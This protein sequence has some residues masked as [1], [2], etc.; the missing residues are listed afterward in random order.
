MIGE[1]T[2]A[3]MFLLPTGAGQIVRTAGERKHRLRVVQEN[4]R[5]VEVMF[6][7]G[8]FVKLGVRRSRPIHEF[9]AATSCATARG[10]AL[11]TRRGD[12][13]FPID[14]AVDGI[15]GHRNIPNFDVGFRVVS[16]DFCA[17]KPDCILCRFIQCEKRFQGEH[18][19]LFVDHVWLIE[20]SALEIT[21]I[22]ITVPNKLRGLRGGI[23]VRFAAIAMFLAHHQQQRHRVITAGAGC[24]HDRGAGRL[25]GA[26]K[27]TVGAL[28]RQKPID[29]LLR[30]LEPPRMITPECFFAAIGAQ[31]LDHIFRDRAEKVRCWRR[32]A[33]RFAETK[34][35]LCPL[36]GRIRRRRDWATSAPN[37]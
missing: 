30:P 3:P 29:V 10:D 14:L 27:R 26:G 35:L 28:L 16:G 34:R 9:I 19:R 2:V 20:R 6:I 4:S 7:A 15:R 23:E 18:A 8:V 13:A 36:A 31:E 5:D 21:A 12:T 32:A 1:A 25:P 33:R 24:I 11:Q 17:I 22:A 37:E